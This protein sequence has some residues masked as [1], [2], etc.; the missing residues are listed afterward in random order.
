MTAPRQTLNLSEVGHDLLTCQ[1]DYAIWKRLVR[2]SALSEWVMP[3]P[4]DETVFRPRDEDERK[5]TRT[6]H[7]LPS[8]APLILYVGRLNIQ[9]NLHTLLQLL[10]TVRREVPEAHLCLVGEDDDIK[11]GEFGVH[12]TGYVAW[13]GSLA[14]ELGV[15]EHVIPIC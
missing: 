14:E 4:V 1:A 9:K 3:L 6:R 13:L 5:T 11:Q 2:W 7:D 15:A 10:T 8:D 12:N